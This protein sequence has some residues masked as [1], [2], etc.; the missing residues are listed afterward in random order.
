MA[1]ILCRN[2]LQVIYK[3]DGKKDNT[4]I[5]TICTECEEEENKNVKADEI[6][7]Y[8]EE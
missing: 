5:F 7:E 1:T 2:C 4:I 3:D 8:I 6:V